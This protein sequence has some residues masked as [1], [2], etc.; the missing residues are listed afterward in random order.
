MKGEEAAR[1]LLGILPAPLK[2]QL[3]RSLEDIAGPRTKLAKIFDDVSTDRRSFDNIIRGTAFYERYIYP[4]TAAAADVFERP[5]AY[6]LPLVTC[7][8]LNH[9]AGPTP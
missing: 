5:Q 8:K 3:R 6:S 2:W 7:R 4:L 9:G 1:Q